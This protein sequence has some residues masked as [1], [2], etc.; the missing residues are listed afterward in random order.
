MP[1]RAMIRTREIWRGFLE[2]EGWIAVKEEQPAEG[3]LG[4]P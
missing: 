3:I 4:G 2:S 1:R